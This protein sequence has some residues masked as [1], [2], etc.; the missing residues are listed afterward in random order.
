MVFSTHKSFPVPAV[1]PGRAA[2]EKTS[3][4]PVVR[5]IA[6]GFVIEAIAVLAVWGGVHLYHTL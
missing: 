3:R 1:F 6:I 2:V 5:G 4:T